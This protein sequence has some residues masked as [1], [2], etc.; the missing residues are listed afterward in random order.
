[1]TCDRPMLVPVLCLAA[2]V[3]LPP[4]VAPERHVLAGAP[5]GHLLLL[6]GGN[7]PHA[8]VERFLALAGGA[9]ARIVVL[10]LASEDSRG[11]GG[12]YLRLFAGWGVKDVDVIH[13]DDRRDAM[14]RE[15]AA[16]VRHATGV[17]FSGGDQR[18]ISGR[19]VDTPLLEALREMK[20][21]G[22]VV[23]GTSA[24]TACQSAL[25]L[26]GEG[27][28]NVIR[29]NTVGLSR[30]LGLFPGVILYSHFVARRRSERLIS[31]VLEHPDQIGVGV[32]EGTAIWARAD[33]LWEVLGDGWVV[34]YDARAAEITRLP[35]GRLGAQGLREAVLVA[36]QTFDPRRHG[37]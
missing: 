21:R 22:G 1:M 3:H 35:D 2:C 31:V 37:L 6:G 27:A 8:F 5:G 30:G 17:M 10:P 26:V 7:K 14:R 23:A 29:G 18:R 13:I 20:A 34:V 4:G 16:R 36:G 12:D 24:G 28:E 25:M 15:Y 33:G 32:D 11:A 19:L 9:Q